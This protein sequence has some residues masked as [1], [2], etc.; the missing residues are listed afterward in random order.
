[1]AQRSRARS[2]RARPLTG[3]WGAT[4]TIRASI[5]SRWVMTL[6]TRLRASS[7]ARASPSVSVRCRS[8]IA[9][10]V[11]WPNSASKTAASA[12]RRPVRKA[13]IRSGWLSAS[14]AID[15]HCDRL[16]A[17]PEQPLD[18]GA[19]RGSHVLGEGHEMLAG[20]G[21]DPDVDPDAVIREAGH[22]RRPGEDRPPG[23]SA[24]RDAGDTR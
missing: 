19:D 15:G 3:Y 2:I 21:D 10:A 14:D 9:S 13:R 1:M 20:P 12:R 16:Q 24:A 17:E 22:D 11:R 7:A 4:A 6:A 5:V 23:R 8:R 18:G